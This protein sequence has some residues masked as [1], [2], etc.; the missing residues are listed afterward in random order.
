MK[1]KI[2]V[3]AALA[4]VMFS[5]KDDAKTE[6]GKAGD[7]KTTS[8]EGGSSADGGE[9]LED[10]S[11]LLRL[12]YPKGFKQEL[13]YEMSTKAQGMEMDMAMVMK[14][15]VADVKEGANPVFDIDAKIASM[16]MN[17]TAMGEK[18]NYDSSKAEAKM[19][20]E[21][22]MMHQEM[23]KMINQPIAFSMDSKGKMV[24][25]MKFTGV[26]TPNEPL[27]MSSYQVAYPEK[28]V[29]V[30]DT[31]TNEIENKQY[32]GKMKC[33]Y[34]VKKITQEDVE[35][36]FKA[37]IPPMKGMDKS[38]TFNGSY[39]V[40][41]ATGMV[42]KGSMGGKMAMMNADIKMTFTGKKV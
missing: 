22:K 38:T 9:A 30:G 32:G 23:K 28:P 13:V 35:L 16:K 10:G 21:E 42:L 18:I 12:N 39:T 8:A 36:G 17:T 15:D 24:G 6:G 31:W 4:F 19:S 40:D 29:K 37:T 25:E 26:D 3:A 41:R 7:E 33:T 20:E 5:C 1:V 27:D 11:A 34:T 2:Y 14:M